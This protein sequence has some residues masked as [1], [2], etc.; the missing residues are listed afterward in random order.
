M[1][2]AKKCENC[3]ADVATP[4]ARNLHAQIT[5]DADNSLLVLSANKSNVKTHMARALCREIIAL[6]LVKRKLEAK[7]KL[8]S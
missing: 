8:K 6:K 7:S 3:L 5:V 1:M 4:I 2:K